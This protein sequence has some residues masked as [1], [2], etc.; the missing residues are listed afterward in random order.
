MLPRGVVDRL[1]AL[2]GGPPADLTP[3][4][5][6]DI[7]TAAAWRAADGARYFVKC[8]DELGAEAFAAEA[9][10]LARLRATR[11]VS[12]PEVVVH[13]EADGTGYLVLGWI[14]PG[15]A[16]T[17]AWREL[18]EA[19]AALHAVTA[20][21]Y[22]LDDDNLI[23]RLPQSNRKRG[24]WARFWA[25]E[26][27]GRQLALARTKGRVDSALTRRI[28]RLCD[29][30]ERICDRAGLRPSLL[31][32]DL[33]SGNVMFST[34]GPMV[35]DPAVYYG[36]REVELAFTELFGGFADAFYAAYQAA[37][38]LADGYAQRRGFWQLYPLLVHLNLFGGSYLGGV[39]RAVRAG[40]ALL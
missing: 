22:G 9:D 37:A 21:D 31:H 2:L 20:P 30:V 8:N 29:E 35:I 16:D 10:G 15:R 5:G 28:E 23:G 6:G 3:V 26:R 32:G 25:E 17:R 27:I 33:W 40:E 34:H 14:E 11:T 12:V 7:N 38:P 1:A 39:E 4:S 19:L 24:G 36:D 13:G 18:G